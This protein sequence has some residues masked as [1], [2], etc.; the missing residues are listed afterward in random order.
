MT[1][2]RRSVRRST[3]ASV[4]RQ[5]AP[6]TGISGTPPTP[7][8]PVNTVA[9]LV[10]GSA[11]EGSV[12]T[13]STGTWTG[14]PAPTFSYQWRADG[15][16]IS[17]Q[18]NNTYTTLNGD[19]GKAI[20]CRVTGSNASGTPTGTVSSNSITVTAASSRSTAFDPYYTPGQQLVS[21][22]TFYAKPTT[23]R[24]ATRASSYASASYVRSNFGTRA[25]RVTDVADAIGVAGANFMRQEYSRK[26]AFNSD[27]TLF[28]ARS[29]GGYWW[30]Y[31]AVT[32][33]PINGGRTVNPGMGGLG[34]GSGSVFG[35]D[36]EA[37]WH[38]T[39]PNK[40]W[41]TDTNGSLVWYEFNLTTKVTTTL[42][43][44]TS[45]CAAA[46]MTGA[47]RAWFQGEGRCSD[48]GRYW[49]FSIQD[50][51]FNQVAIACYDR[52]AHA[53]TGFIL[54]SNKPNNVS[55]TP[56]GL[57]VIPSWS[58]VGSMTMAAA[59]AAAIGSTNGARAY[60]RAM[61]TFQQLSYYGEHSDT[62][63]DAAGN[64]VLISVNYNAGNMPDVTDGGIYY[65]RCDNGVAYNTPLNVYATAGHSVHMSGC[66]GTFTPGWAVVGMFG[67]TANLYDGEILLLELVTSGA[68]VLRLGHHE[69][70][71]I[72]Y[73]SE[74]HTTCSRDMTKFINATDF[75]G[76]SSFESVMT[77]IASGMLPVAG[78][79]VPSNTVAPVVSGTSAP[80][81]TLT[82]STGT[83]SASPSSYAYQWQKDGVDISGQTTN[84]FTVPGSGYNGSVVRCNVSA[85]NGTGTGGPAPS[86]GVTIAALAAPVNTVAPVV[87]GG[88]AVG[89][90]LTCTS[91]GTW[92]GNPT[93][94]LASRQWKKAGVNIS[95]ETGATY[96]TVTG[97]IGS[98]I[99]CS[100]SYTN[101]QGTVAAAS[102]GITVAAGG[103]GTK[104]T[105]SSAKTPTGS[106]L[107][108]GNMTYTRTN[109]AAD[110]HYQVG[111]ASGGFYRS[112][113]TYWD[114]FLWGT[115]SSVP[116]NAI[117]FANASATPT[118]QYL[119]ASGS[120]TV[121]INEQSTRGSYTRDFNGS[122]SSVGTGAKQINNG[123][124]VGVLTK[125]ATGKFFVYIHD[126]SSG[127]WLGDDPNVTPSGGF[128]IGVSGAVA[129]ACAGY[130]QNHT[131][132]YQT[133]AQHTLYSLVSGLGATQQWDDA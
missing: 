97:D 49:G 3:S 121:G 110:V 17:G 36:C 25:Y 35:A 30:V 55:I 84:A 77:G 10:S 34:S 19:V 11:V 8:A 85:T 133:A 57:Y 89:S 115:G 76:G 48:D 70:A 46:G 82:C 132:T 31:D 119:G 1:I 98:A 26:P 28:M 102:N 42:F 107:S 18:T 62:A 103:A 126:G 44:L 13:C 92:T 54:T 14:Y 118:G 51:G 101:S 78:T 41:R 24:P 33:A 71:V 91:D 123:S 65:R 125:V 52:Q 106:T 53:F 43:D 45:L 96:T 47:A 61:T 60:N 16:D 59:A 32:M 99:T 23:P 6:G 20:T 116:Y 129:L 127:A 80:G 112:T 4:R 56:D 87:S 27:G 109:V 131:I 58:N 75:N 113:G 40:I 12:L 21:N 73:W 50:N 67:G 86:N 7:A 22:N 117:G 122:G 111:D 68:R 128:A 120:T 74:P 15:S 90:L 104:A 5:T 100:V 2:V 94:T 66:G 114:E 29:A 9:P 88:T 83:W 38:P 93:P 108:N 95:G 81:G 72:D 63:M 130:A 69:S 37:L 124:R 105:F 79:I 64:A 39:D